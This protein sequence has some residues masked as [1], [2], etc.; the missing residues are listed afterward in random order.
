MT[1]MLLMMRRRMG[2]IPRMTITESEEES[3]L[4]PVINLLG[5]SHSPLRTQSYSFLESVILITGSEEDYD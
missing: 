3:Y 5:V 4:E 2:L 1:R